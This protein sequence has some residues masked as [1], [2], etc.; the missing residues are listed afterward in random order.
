MMKSVTHCKYTGTSVVAQ[1]IDEKG[2]KRE[3]YLQD[4]RAAVVFPTGALPGYFVMMGR[5]R[6]IL[7]TGKSP[8]LFL[9]EGENLMHEILFSDLTDSCVKFKCKTIYANLPRTDRKRGVGGFDDLWRYLRNRKLAINLIPAPAADD[10][11]Y[12]RALV[13]EFWIDKAFDIPDPHDRPTILR[14][15]LAVLTPDGEDDKLYA[16]HA[17]RHLLCGFVKFNNVIAYDARPQKSEKA[18]P[19]GWT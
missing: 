10:V 13:R 17:L 1:A 12:G 3:V 7:P 14:S 5:K 18:N 11:D 19:R 16:F 6:E 15:Q 4:A 2:V 8:L 9:T